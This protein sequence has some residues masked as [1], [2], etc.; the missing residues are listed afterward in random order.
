MRSSYLVFRLTLFLTLSCS[1]GYGQFSTSEKQQPNSE[2]QVRRVSIGGQLDAQGRFAGPD[3]AKPEQLFGYLA[4]RSVQIEL[5]LTDAQIEAIKKIEKS[6]EEYVQKQFANFR[7]TGV[8]PTQQDINATAEASAKLRISGLQEVLL[9]AQLRR[10]YQLA[11]HIDIGVIGLAN[12]FTDGRVGTAIGVTE[13]QFASLKQKIA[14]FEEAAREEQREVQRRLYSK[15]LQELSAEQRTK[16]MDL[17]GDVFNYKETP[18]T[19]LLQDL[20]KGRNS[21]K[22][23]SPPAPAKNK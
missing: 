14:R 1:F 21:Q 2:N 22:S 13:G 8:R 11:F 16:A 9:P 18:R 10:L 17:M 7:E 12:A 4:N 3:P 19:E 20:V 15:I 23:S 6:D 5:G